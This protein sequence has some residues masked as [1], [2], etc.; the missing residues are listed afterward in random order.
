M[1]LCRS[2]RG[3]GLGVGVKARSRSQLGMLFT[4]L[5]LEE[6]RNMPDFKIQTTCHGSHFQFL[7]CPWL[8]ESCG[9][10]VHR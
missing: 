7:L 9:E 6:V 5:G 1:G 10:S 3:A 2:F 8:A 4:E